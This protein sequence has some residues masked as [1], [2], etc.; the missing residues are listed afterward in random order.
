M[1]C[2]KCGSKN[3]TEGCMELRQRGNICP[4]CQCFWT[5]WQQTEIDQL[6]QN[7]ADALDLSGFQTNESSALRAC[8][9]EIANH[10]HCNYEQDSCSQ[11]DHIEQRQGR[12]LYLQGCTDGHRCSAEI[13]KLGLAKTKG[14]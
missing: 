13:A 12:I 14:E 2:P 5:E 3:I 4:R 10:P 9:E 8:L 1:K 11:V 7:L 6:N